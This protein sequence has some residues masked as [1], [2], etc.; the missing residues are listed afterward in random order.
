MVFFYDESMHTGVSFTLKLLEKHKV[1]LKIM[2]FCCFG[3]IVH[4]GGSFLPVVAEYIRVGT[5]SR[6]GLFILQQPSSRQRQKG[7]RVPTSSLKASP[8]PK[9]NLLTP[10]PTS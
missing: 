1:L 3:S 2:F 5:R 10:G 6:G 7:A 8:T 9:P 4:Q